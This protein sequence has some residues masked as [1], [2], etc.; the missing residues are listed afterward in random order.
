V[1]RLAPY[2]LLSSLLFAY[3]ATALMFDA[4]LAF[5]VALGLYGLVVAR[6]D[7]GARGFVWLTLAL[8]GALYAKGPVALLHL[9]PAALAAPWWAGTPPPAGWRRWYAGIGLAVLGGAALILA[10]AIPA[11]MAG[12]AEYRDAIFWGQTAGRV[13]SSFAHRAPFWFYL[14]WLPLMLLPWLTS[15]RCWRGLA[16]ARREGLLAEPGSRLMLFAAGFALLAFSLVSGK[17]WHYLLPEF[18]PFALLAARVALAATP[19]PVDRTL[20][21]AGLVLAGVAL[22]LA[23]PRLRGPLADVDAMPVLI[24]AGVA[25]AAIGLGLWRWRVRSPTG[26]LRAIAVAIV[27]AYAVGLGTAD[28]LLREPFDVDRTAQQLARYEAEGR[29]VGIVGDYH[30]QWHLAGRLQRPLQEVPHGGGAAWLAAHPD[31]RLLVV[32]KRDDELPAGTR[33][34]FEQPRYRGS[35]LTIVAPG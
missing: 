2:V 25:L 27:L 29:P 19:R 8:G 14:A 15:P 28:R 23:A 35:R 17:R 11:A 26:D 5:F 13:T 12:G 32:H 10:W 34:D 6:Q 3:F 24:G 9:L 18:A 16:A 22:A 20:A 31:G 30:G 1:A 33:A 21:A 4:M 7:G